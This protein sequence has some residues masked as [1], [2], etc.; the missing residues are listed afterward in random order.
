M[1]RE[2]PKQAVNTTTRGRVCAATGILLV[3]C[4]LSA[5]GQSLDSALLEVGRC[6]KAGNHLQEETLRLAAG[7]EME[8]QLA[9]KRDAF[10]GSAASAT[11]HFF[12]PINEQLNHEIFPQGRSTPLDQSLKLLRK[13]QQSSYC[14][15][16]IEK[17]LRVK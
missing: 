13:W 8:R 7:A 3:A 12:A 1:N 11:M 16:L 6:Y 9:Q 17:S 5:C 10:K 2:K 14:Q 15:G 4:L